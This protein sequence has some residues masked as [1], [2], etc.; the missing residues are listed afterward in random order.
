MRFVLL[1]TLMMQKALSR[2]TYDRENRSTRRRI[3]T[4]YQEAGNSYVG[5]TGIGSAERSSSG[6]ISCGGDTMRRKHEWHAAYD[7]AV[8]R[9]LGRTTQAYEF[10]TYVDGALD[11]A[12]WYVRPF[13]TLP[14]LFNR[15]RHHGWG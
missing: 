11:Y 5:S 10:A 13:L 2:W 7:Y 3:A 9:G 1:A 8:K 14:K 4:A 6:A 12:P 15:F